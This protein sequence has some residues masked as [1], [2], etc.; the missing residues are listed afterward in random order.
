MDIR[1]VLLV[2]RMNTMALCGA[3]GCIGGSAGAGS[4]AGSGEGAVALAMAV[5]VAGGVGV[6]REAYDVRVV[7]DINV[8]VNFV[9]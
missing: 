6:G 3:S 4:G 5:A 8:L 7:S 9:R 1:D 2:G